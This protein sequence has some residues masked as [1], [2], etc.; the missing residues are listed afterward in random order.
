MGRLERGLFW[1]LYATLA[2]SLVLVSVLGAVAW[3]LTMLIRPSPGFHRPAAH[4]LM[5]LLG[6][7][8]AVGV[9]AYPV[10]GRLTRRLEQLKGSVEAWGA[11]ALA[12]RAKVEGNDEIAAVSVSFN[13]AADR[14]EALLAAHKALLA[15]A[16]HELRSPLTRLRVASEI[17]LA[18]PRPELQAAITRE[19]AEL[20]A[21]VDE[22]LL[23]SRLD[24]GDEPGP[25]ETCDVLAL[26]AE[27]AARASVEL[28]PVAADG[29]A[30]EVRGWPRLLRRMIRNLIAN[31][32]QHGEPPV[33]VEIR[34]DSAGRII[35]SVRDHGEGIS[36]EERVRVFEPFYRPA[37]RPET[38]GGWGL[39]LSLVRQIAERHGGTVVCEAAE[40]AGAAFV[41]ALPAG[42]GEPA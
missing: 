29:Q 6:T 4:L 17:Y 21:L 10:I 24:H 22:I 20:D 31:A 23:A 2:V 14:V 18:S 3:H 5:M 37:G 1:R 13:T 36:A 33:Q 40:G 30:F 38:E 27:E 16:S 15:H 12:T 9:A 35:I 42:S 25:P 8:A 26:A 41:V 7:A 32:L 28:L 34:G 19:V 39:G 11:G